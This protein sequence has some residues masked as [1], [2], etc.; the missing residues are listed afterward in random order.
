MTD[1]SL[2]DNWSCS[3]GQYVTC[4]IYPEVPCNK[5]ESWKREWGTSCLFS[6]FLNFFAL[7]YRIVN[8]RN[9][10]LRFVDFRWS[11][12]LDPSLLLSD[13]LGNWI[14]TAS[15]QTITTRMGASGADYMMVLSYGRKPQTKSPW[16]SHCKAQVIL[17][18]ISFYDHIL[19]NFF[20]YWINLHPLCFHIKKVK[21]VDVIRP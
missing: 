13:L 18:H 5:T 11:L 15:P 14:A 9:T 6:S 2:F 4:F 21:L 3:Q 17:L 16:V 19:R 12:P 10:I 20:S 1:D 7:F 8:K